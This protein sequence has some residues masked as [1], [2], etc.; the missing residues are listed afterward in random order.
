MDHVP[1]ATP[2][3]PTD[4]PATP[5][6]EA[7]EPPTLVGVLLAIALVRSAVA[8]F[9]VLWQTGAL[10]STC[11]EMRDARGAFLATRTA[12]DAGGDGEYRITDKGLRAYVWGCPKLSSLNFSYC[13]YITDANLQYVAHYCPQI[14]AVNLSNCNQITNAA[15]IALA[16]GCHQLKRLKLS[17]CDVITDAAVL[18]LSQ[19][20]PQLSFL[21]LALCN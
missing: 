1:P 20:C 6:E 15:V 13:S 21:S 2:E 18:A 17:F 12:L 10:L 11:K 16:Q 4:A 19:G 8:D 9:C 14:S 5:G 3:Q 7:Y